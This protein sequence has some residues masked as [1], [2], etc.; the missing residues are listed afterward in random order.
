MQDNN[1]VS[2]FPEIHWFAE[3]VHQ[4]NLYVIYFLNSQTMILNFTELPVAG[5]SVTVQVNGAQQRHVFRTHDA[6]ADEVCI[7]HHLFTVCVKLTWIWESHMEFTFGGIENFVFLAIPPSHE[8]Q[9][10]V[11]HRNTLSNPQHNFYSVSCLV[12]MQATHE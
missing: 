6:E 1:E 11:H 12:V 8:R 9:H 4:M 2:P 7:N 3:S 10:G 5:V